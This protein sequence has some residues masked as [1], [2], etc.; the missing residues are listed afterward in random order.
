MISSL[1]AA[2]LFFRGPDFGATMPNAM[3]QESIGKR[4]RRVRI[5]GEIQQGEVAK[6]AGVSQPRMSAIERGGGDISSSQLRD[7]AACLGVSADYLLGVES[8][9]AVHEPA[10]TYGPGHVLTKSVGAMLR[11]K[12]EGAEVP[13]D[14]VAKALGVTPRV[15]E[16][17]EAGQRE[18]TGTQ[19]V[20]YAQ[21]LSIAPGDLLDTEGDAG[22]ACCR[23][24]RACPEVISALEQLVS[25]ADESVLAHLYDQIDLLIHAARQKKSEGARGDARTRKRQS[26]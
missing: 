13:V 7:I 19:I 26:G 24:R 22:N 25:E 10:A 17:V 15:I 8:E 16:E 18:I 3:A 14:V 11:E 23:I 5:E 1:T 9:P 2:Q 21:A 4:I 12:R 6:A 20:R